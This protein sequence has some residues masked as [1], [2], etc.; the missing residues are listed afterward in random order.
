MAK[1]ENPFAKIEGYNCFGCSPDNPIGLHLEFY[2]EGDEVIAEWNPSHN[3]QGYRGILHGG[4]QA[5]L[6][7]EIASWVVLA[8]L[9]KVGFTARLNIRYKK[10]VP[11]NGGPLQMRAKVNA[12]SHRIA[13][14]AI[15]LT[16]RNGI[17]CA[18]ATAHY[19][20]YTS[21]NQTEAMAPLITK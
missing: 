20:T 9:K 19:F 8:K 21:E 11:V 12:E 4:I 14:I 2:E 17:I 10:S 7:D 16:D 13:E 6:M 18:E 1:V 15:I 5:T 3:Y